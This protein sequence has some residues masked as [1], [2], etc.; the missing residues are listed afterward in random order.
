MEL[1]DKEIMDAMPKQLHEDLAEVCRLAQESFGKAKV[2]GMFRVCLNRGIVDHCRAAI[3][4]DRAMA[5]LEEKA[6][7]DQIGDGYHTLAELYEHRHSLMLALMCA[8]PDICWFSERHADGA[9]PFNSSEWFIVGAELPSGSITYHLP[10]ELLP[11]AQKTGAASLS[12]GLSWDGHNSAD[13]VDRL[14]AWAENGPG[15]PMITGHAPSAKKVPKS[16]EELEASFRSWFKANNGIPPSKQAA[17]YAAAFAL[18]I[19][20]EA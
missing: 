1:T 16:T 5:V 4:A 14:R 3:A 12:R 2:A 10:I 15:L 13:V 7:Q 18:H 17:G 19:L 9:L 20:N 8:K 6:G 11:L